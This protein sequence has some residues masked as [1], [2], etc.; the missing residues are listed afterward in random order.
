M[1][2]KARKMI[3][4]LPGM[5]TFAI[6]AALAILVAVPVGVAL[7]QDAVMTAGSAPADFAVEPASADG[8]TTLTLSW[9]VPA[10]ALMW[11]HDDN[12]QTDEQARDIR[13]YRIDRSMDGGDTWKYHDHVADSD[14]TTDVDELKPGT[15]H[16]FRIYAVYLPTSISSN[17]DATD[18]E[19]LISPPAM[20]SGTT[21]GTSADDAP[22]TPL[23]F[24]AT[25]EAITATGNTG[26]GRLQLQWTNASTED[27]PLTY[28]LEYSMNNVN[29]MPLADE[30]GSTASGEAMPDAMPY[31]TREDE[32]PTYMGN[33]NGL[34]QKTKYYYRIRAVNADDVPG[35]WATHSATTRAAMKPAVPQLLVAH[36]G[37]GKIT[38][39]WDAPN[40]PAGAP[41]TGY[42]IMTDNAYND[43][44]VTTDFTVLVG[45][46]P[47]ADTM[48]VHESLSAGTKAYYQIYAINAAGE[49][50]ASNVAVGTATADR[51]TDRLPAPEDLQAGHTNADDMLTT[52]VPV[53]ERPGKLGLK[54]VMVDDADHYMIQWSPD[55][56]DGNW[57][58][59][60]A[61]T[62]MVALE[63]MDA[64]PYMR[65][66]DTEGLHVGLM[67]E[68]T[69]YYQVFAVGEDGSRQSLPSETATGTTTNAE[70]PAMPEELSATAVGTQINLTWKALDDPAGAPVTGFRIDRMKKGG[71]WLT[72]A[73]VGD[74]M[75]YSDAGLEPNTEYTYRI[76]AKNNGTQVSGMIDN[77]SNARGRSVASTSVTAT[78]GAGVVVDTTLGEPT[79]T[80]AT[81]GT[82]SVTVAWTDGANAMSHMVLL[83]NTDFSLVAGSVVANATSPQTIS[84]ASGTYILVVLALDADA[85]FEY[86]SDFVTVN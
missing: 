63:A 27:T 66:G 36:G 13:A 58:T 40:N 38:L 46:T 12:A 34:T 16:H 83:L 51:A 41:I 43:D 22:D 45:M 77:V 14:R 54:W 75:S 53:A 68:T 47:D 20:A 19:E 15:T 85:E 5:A 72:I 48:H 50:L 3:W 57:R 23:G 71:N 86:D 59:L 52:D 9:E 8:T 73:N 49:S 44:G 35:D 33:H 30:V 84:V 24:Q 79:I 31:G 65:V 2:T 64:S 78:T 39:Y 37:P 62:S 42:R 80:S 70:V 6:V 21:Q 69:Y 76:Y 28:K 26:A 10:P 61:D 17:S 18:V 67:A 11:D 74:V 7:A 1:R 56:E 4:P 32:A 82:G 60:V 55:G 29:W 81:G 25:A